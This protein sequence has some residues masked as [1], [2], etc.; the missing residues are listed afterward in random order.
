LKYVIHAPSGCFDA[1]ADVFKCQPGLLL[2]AR[3]DCPFVIVAADVRE[4]GCTGDIE[5]VVDQ[6]GTREGAYS[7]GNACRL[8]DLLDRHVGTCASCWT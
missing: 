4:S 5:M 1:F 6:D 8:N 7:L 3:R 2:D